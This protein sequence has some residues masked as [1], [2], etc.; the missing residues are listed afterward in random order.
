MTR[1]EFLKLSGATAGLL[2]TSGLGIA[3]PT[4][5]KPKVSPLL[6]RTIHSTG[7]KI[8]AVGLGT[9][10]DFGNLKADFNQRKN[11]IA[12]LLR[13]GATVI[14]TSPS[15]KD[16]EQVIGRALDE[17]GPEARKKCFLATKTSIHGKQAGIDQN[18]QSFKDL[19]MKK[20]DL[21]Q[22]HNLKDTEAHLETINALKE[23]GKVRYVGITHFRPNLNDE[24]TKV[25]KDHKVDFIQCQYNLLDR[26]IEEK[27]LPMARDRGVAVMVNV[28]FA[29]GKLFSSTVA[30]GIEIP[31]WSKEFGVNSWGQFFLK[32]ILGHPDVTVIIPGTTKEKHVIDNVGALRGRIPTPA[33]RKKMLQLI[34]AL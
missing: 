25:M 26:S 2:A 30:K 19:N 7:E 34:Q 12:A 15:Y 20:F 18:T 3:N 1:K 28:P 32:Y 8:P 17:L 6:H 4:D 29:R 10:M 14:D 16:A 27:V 9:A 24:A 11:A 33:E 22:V 31:E 23:A 5:S 13:E 21:L